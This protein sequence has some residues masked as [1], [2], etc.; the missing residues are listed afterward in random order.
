MEISKDTVLKNQTFHSPKKVRCL[1]TG[2]IKI[3]WNLGSFQPKIIYHRERVV[4]IGSGMAYQP[5]SN[6]PTTLGLQPCIFSCPHCGHYGATIISYKTGT[7]TW[8]LCGSI[9]SVGSVPL[10]V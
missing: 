9:C 1:K 3:T 8:L 5:P 2:E 6:T 4:K 10:N 7:M